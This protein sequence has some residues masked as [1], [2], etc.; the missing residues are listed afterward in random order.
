MNLDLHH[1]NTPTAVYF[2]M[3]SRAENGLYDR[4]RDHTKDQA[5]G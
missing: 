3:T 4:L 5:A 2:G 1:P